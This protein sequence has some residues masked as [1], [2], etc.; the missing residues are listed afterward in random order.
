MRLLQQ[1]WG[2][3]RRITG[4]SIFGFGLQWQPR[5]TA[6]EQATD[7]ADVRVRLVGPANHARFIIAN[8][9]QGAAYDVHFD[10]DLEEGKEHPL[11]KGDYDEKLPIEVLRSGDQVELLAALT[12]GSGIVFKCQWSW[13]DEDGKKRQRDEKISL[14]RI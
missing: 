1:L 7:P 10:I 9:S 14:Q 4:L 5:Q 11:V 8:V 6:A 2:H 13:R 3:I 12:S